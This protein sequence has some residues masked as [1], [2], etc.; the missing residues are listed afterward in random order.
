MQFYIYLKCIVLVTVV[1]RSKACAVFAH[2]KAGIVGS[3]PKQGVDIWY[4]YVFILFVLSF[5]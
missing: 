1:E 4:V 2:S 5:V 3:N